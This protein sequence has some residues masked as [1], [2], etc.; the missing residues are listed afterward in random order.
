MTSPTAP[1]RRWDLRALRREAATELRM[2]TYEAF[3]NGVLGSDAMPRLLRYAGYRALGLAIHTPNV[4]GH[5]HLGVGDPALVSIGAG[6]F[7]NRSCFI[8]AV[9]PV[10]IGRDCQLGMEVGIVT[11][12]HPIGADGSRSRRPVGLPVTIGDRAWLGAR[13]LVLPG[14]RIGADVTIGAGSV[15]VHDCLLPGL[16]AGA[17]ARLMRPLQRPTTPPADGPTPPAN[18]PSPQPDHTAPAPAREPSPPSPADAR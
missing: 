10:T 11:S 15:V 14:V 17:P 8:E 9:G 12:H 18:G 5:V 7:V 13:V 4:A 1:G 2:I 16:Y 6:T 3:L